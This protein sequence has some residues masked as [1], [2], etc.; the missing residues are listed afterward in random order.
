MILYMIVMLYHIKEPILC[1]CIYILILYI[2][3]YTPQP[4]PKSGA[5]EDPDPDQGHTSRPPDHD[6]QSPGEI[7]EVE[8]IIFRR[9]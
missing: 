8:P 9:E 6:V 2:Y 7:F 3:I 1:V 4:T 5:R